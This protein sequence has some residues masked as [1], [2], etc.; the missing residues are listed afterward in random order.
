MKKYKLLKPY[1]SPRTS[2]REGEIK[3]EKEWLGIFN[4][5]RADLDAKSDW[6]EQVMTLDELATPNLEEGKSVEAY[7]RV[8]VNMVL[9]HIAEKILKKS[10]PSKYAEQEL[11][12][13]YFGLNN[14][15]KIEYKSLE[16]GYVKGMEDAIN[17]I[18]ELI[19]ER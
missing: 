16:K 14:V 3:T 19:E 7:L 6:F 5:T 17:I 1:N 13:G 4:L 10:D 12:D 11:G 9:Q 15:G 2:I 8:T 18:K